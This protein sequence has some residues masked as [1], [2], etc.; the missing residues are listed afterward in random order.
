M[1][2]LKTSYGWRGHTVY[3]L[4]NGRELSIVTNKNFHGDLVTN[5]TAGRVDD[6]LFTFVLL[7]DFSERVTWSVLR[8]TEKNV[9]EQHAH[10]LA[11]ETG[12]IARAE[13]H[14]AKK[15]EI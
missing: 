7:S 10:A 3:P 12:L 4:S 15:G 6:D 9:R 13:A 14:Y 1:S 5:A 8:C 11:Q 2:I